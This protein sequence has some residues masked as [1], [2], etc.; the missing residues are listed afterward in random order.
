MGVLLHEQDSDTEGVYLPDPLREI[1]Y[2]SGCETQRRLVQ[3]SSFG[4]LIKALPM[5]SIC[6]S[7]PLRVPPLWFRLSLSLG[8]RAYMFS[9]LSAISFLSERR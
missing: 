9:R 1:Q 3:E 6:C 2:C 5:A 7:P 8:K 4:L